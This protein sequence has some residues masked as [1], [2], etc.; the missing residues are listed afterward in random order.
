MSN[1]ITINCDD[2]RIDTR[3]GD[4][5][6]KLV[7]TNYNASFLSEIDMSEILSNVDKDI[8]FNK[9]IEWNKDILCNYLE[10]RGYKFNKN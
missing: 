4:N 1:K 5:Q 10:Q 7:I 9:L 3:H 2:V 8:L 6:I